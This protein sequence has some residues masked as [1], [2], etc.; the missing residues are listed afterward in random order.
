MKMNMER[1]K[2]KIYIIRCT[3]VRIYAESGEVGLTP[4]YKLVLLQLV[5]T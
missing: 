5:Q 3:P 2:V 1:W 4:T